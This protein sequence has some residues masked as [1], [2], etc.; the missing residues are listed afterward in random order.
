M[1]VGVFPWSAPGRGGVVSPGS[2]GE[3]GLG[4]W[5][6][7][8]HSRLTILHQS[9]ARLQEGQARYPEV[10]NTAPKTDAQGDRRPPRRR[11]QGHEQDAKQGDDRERREGDD[12]ELGAGEVVA[13]GRGVEDG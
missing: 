7:Q 10:A 12:Q 6:Q 1:V 9:A 8:N 11:D 4:E 5:S 13:C 2:I 3:A